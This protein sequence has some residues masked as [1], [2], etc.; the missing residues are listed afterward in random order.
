VH[1]TFDNIVGIACGSDRFNRQVIQNR[2]CRVVL[3][4]RFRR[5]DGVNVGIVTWRCRFQKLRHPPQRLHHVVP[6]RRISH[7]LDPR[8]GRSFA[9]GSPPRTEAPLGAVDESDQFVCV[10]AVQPGSMALEGGSRPRFDEAGNHLTSRQTV[11]VHRDRINQKWRGLHFWR[12]LTC[13]REEPLPCV[14]G[15]TVVDRFV[16]TVFTEASRSRRRSLRPSPSLRSCE[17]R[18]LI[19]TSGPA[20]LRADPEG[21]Q[22]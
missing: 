10:S 8:L 15:L 21:G 2:R 12:A 3:R 7:A 1:G 14:H 22:P 18:G 11:R 13:A 4:L 19:G 9:L 16:Q 20:P 5:R 6:P 17:V